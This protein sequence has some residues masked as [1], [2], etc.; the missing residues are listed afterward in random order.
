MSLEFASTSICIDPPP[1]FPLPQG[2][3]P[4]LL[5]G[6]PAKEPK[7]IL[8]I[9]PP[10]PDDPSLALLRDAVSSSIRLEFSALSAAASTLD[11][12]SSDDRMSIRSLCL[13]IVRSPSSSIC[14]FSSNGSLHST[15]RWL[16]FMWQLLLSHLA[17]PPPSA[18]AARA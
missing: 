10:A 18:A 15:Y 8:R 3:L 5:A 6:L 11:W 7:D 1:P 16:M 17:S 9:R 2:K 13:A 4:E 12:L 14:S